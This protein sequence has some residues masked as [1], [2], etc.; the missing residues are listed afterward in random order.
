MTIQTPITPAPTELEIIME[1][2]ETQ[3]RRSAA[4]MALSDGIRD[5][6]IAPLKAAK[7]DPEAERLVSDTLRAL[8]P[9]LNPIDIDIINDAREH[10]DYINLCNIA[11]DARH[12]SEHIDAEI[13]DRLQCRAAAI[14]RRAEARGADAYRARM[15]D[16]KTAYTKAYEAAMKLTP[17]RRRQLAE[18]LLDS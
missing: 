17:S 16:R 1:Q 2:I 14:K 4:L 18:A 7:G 8:V 9:A 10:R 6:K 5:L 13:I 12:R 15:A 3:Q 11:R